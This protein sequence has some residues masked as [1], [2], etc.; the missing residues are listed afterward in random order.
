[1]ILVPLFDLKFLNELAAGGVGTSNRRHW[2]AAP[3]LARLNAS[4]VSEILH[5]VRGA[6]LTRKISFAGAAILGCV[7]LSSISAGAQSVQEFYA[8]HPISISVGS[9]PGGGYDVYA[10]TFAKYFPLHM[11]GRPKIVVE[12]VPA[13]AGDAAA[14]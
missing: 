13:A 3:T 9:D 7:T 12:Y 5:E 4:V 6:V 10:R 1:M 8:S 11:P 2:R 14:P